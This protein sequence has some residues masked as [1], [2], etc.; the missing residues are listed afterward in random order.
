MSSSRGAKFYRKW[1]MVLTICGSIL[2]IVGSQQAQATLR[3]VKIGIDPGHGGSDTGAVGPT[4][5]KEADVNLSTAQAANNYFL[6][7]GAIVFM[8]RMTDTTMSLTS[9]TDYFNSNNVD[10]AIS[11]HHNASAPSANAT[12]DFVYCGYCALTNG[13]LASRVIERVG[14]ATG[15]PLG[16]PAST[17]DTLCASRSDWACE[18][19]GVGQ[20][21]LAMVRQTSMPA[22]LVEVSFITNPTEESRLRNS[23]YLDSNGRAIY[24]G[25]ADH[26]GGTQ[27]DNTPPIISIFN[28]SPSTLTLGQSFTI[29]YTVSDSGGS[30][31]NGVVLRRTF[32]DG[33]QSDPGWHNII[34][35]AVSGNGPVSGSISDTPPSV[36]TYWYGMAA[37]DYSGNSKDERQSGLGPQQV[38][39]T[40]I[41]QNYTL[42]VTGGGNGQGTVTGPGISCTI[43]AGSASGACSASY[44]AGTVV[45]LN[46]TPIGASTFNGWGGACA[47]TGSCILPMNAGMSVS[48]SFAAFVADYTLTVMGGGNGQGTV[49]GSGISCTISAGSASGA[50]SVFYALGTVVSLT[51]TPTGGSTF[52]GWGGAC[53]GTGGC[54]VT[55]NTNISVSANFS[56]GT[57]TA[58]KAGSGAGT[59]TS[60]VGIINCG[61]ICSD[62][63]ANGT[64]IT[65]TATPVGGSQFTGWLGPCT[66]VG[67][68]QFTVNGPTTVLATFASPVIDALKLDIDGTTSCDA[69]TDGLLVIRYLLGL[70]GASLI[71]GAVGPGAARTTPAQIGDFLIDIRPA[72]DIDG[73]GQADALTDGLL[74]IR[75]LFGLRGASLIAGAVG[76]GAIRTIAGDIE[77]QI[78]N[79]C[80]PP[81]AN[82]VLSGFPSPQI[83]RV[84]GNVTVVA[85]DAFG[86]TAA[87]YLGAVHF[88]SSDLQASLPGDY[89]FSGAD[90]GVHTFSVTLKTSGTQSITATDT[91]NGSITESQSGITVNATATTTILTLSSGTNP[92]TFG[93]SLTYTATVTGGIPTGTVTFKD[94][95]VNIGTCA[96]QTVSSSTATCSIASLSAAT[97]PITATYNGD[98]SFSSSPASSTVRQV[99]N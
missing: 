25:T 53:S 97:H 20:A 63:Y 9:R 32:G 24:L 78:L 8:T 45:V 88:T 65:L 34:T 41:A 62:T 31:L 57:L 90:A 71:S 83:S 92:S 84:P 80:L 87:G 4:G 56:G 11:I 94:A 96:S 49:T 98:S 75:Y 2:A 33:T 86:N 37:F 23:A 12:M 22:I 68:C 89:A 1:A 93:S 77:A 30:G 58:T 43:S 61:A 35:S 44:A 16:V 46:A 73:N 3:G 21:N 79:L 55:S 27:G 67:T 48:A 6:G 47:G 13:D 66:G 50:C 81:T 10:R 28:V 51:A 42:T 40:Q 38:K 85:K 91:A 29:N 15:L 19:A 18:I 72:L 95:G 74:I 76:P 82:F 17:S 26:F 54:S 14:V 70:S 99:V 7:D 64:P 36:G 52:S 5:L 69:L 60:N 59:V 39:V